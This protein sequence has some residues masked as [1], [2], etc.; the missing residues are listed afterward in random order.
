MG[1]ATA[2]AKIEIPLILD[3]HRDLS[4]AMLCRQTW[5][6]HQD[7]HGPMDDSFHDARK[8]C[9][10]VMVGT[11][12]Q[13]GIKKACRSGCFLPQTVPAQLAGHLRSARSALAGP[14]VP[15]GL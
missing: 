13:T 14:S 5:R 1:C 12:P 6:S 4:V 10:R 3:C 7:A 8:R 2:Q 11:L 15:S 9:N